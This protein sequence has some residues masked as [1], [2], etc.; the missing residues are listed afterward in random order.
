MDFQLLKLFLNGKS[1]AILKVRSLLQSIS[2]ALLEVQESSQSH[3]PVII[4]IKLTKNEQFKQ[5]FGFSR[6]LSD[7]LI[8]SPVII[9]NMI[10]PGHLYIQLVDQDLPL[11][12]QLQEDLQEEFFS[13]TKQSPSYCPT[14]TAGTI[15]A[16]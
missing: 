3:A 15:Y 7:G 14:P 8:Y 6:A 13:V 11:Y 10:H 5:K 16:I 12:H 1:E 9:T 2:L 4:D